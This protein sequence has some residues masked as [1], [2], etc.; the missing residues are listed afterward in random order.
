MQ[1]RSAAL[2]QHDVFRLDVA[3]QNAGG[4]GVV[5]RFEH[6][7]GRRERVVR[8]HRTAAEPVAQRPSTDVPP[9][10]ERAG[11][12]LAGLVERGNRRMLKPGARFGLAQESLPERG[13]IRVRDHLDRHRPSEREIACQVHGSHP[14]GAQRLFDEIVADRAP[15]HPGIVHV[16]ARRCQGWGRGEGCSSRRKAGSR[17]P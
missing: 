17:R 3:V 12:G 4:V 6:S 9:R 7:E 14:P 8:P 2:A 11:I 5:E 1:L 16:T 13:L 10:N 15:Y